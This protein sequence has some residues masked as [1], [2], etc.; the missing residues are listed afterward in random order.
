MTYQLC[1]ARSGRNSLR[2]VV[3]N[4][5]EWF[6]TDI[7]FAFPPRNQ[8]PDTSN[9]KADH[10]SYPVVLA[11]IRARIFRRTPLVPL[12]RRT[13]HLVR[14]GWGHHSNLFSSN[15]S[16]VTSRKLSPIP[17]GLNESS[18]ASGT[19]GMRASFKSVLIKVKLSHESNPLTHP[20][21]TERR[22]H[23]CPR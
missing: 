13:S 2:D 7:V 3:L 23:R 4:D 20:M 8:V 21:W 5:L 16:W 11:F 6:S 19:S 15:W 12:A 14:Q 10:P 17:Y 1:E 18:T 22:R 9:H